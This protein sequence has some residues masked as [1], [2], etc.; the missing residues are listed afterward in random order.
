M[1]AEQAAVKA[2]EEAIKAVVQNDSHLSGFEEEKMKLTND[3][4][5]ISHLSKEEEN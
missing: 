3:P 2:A 1:E 4:D 5:I